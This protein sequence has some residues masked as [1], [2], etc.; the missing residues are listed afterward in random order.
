[1]AA[2]PFVGAALQLYYAR[3]ARLL[4]PG[5]FAE[6]AAGSVCPVC[7]M[8]PAAAVPVAGGTT[9]DVRML[10]CPLC[11]TAWR[12]VGLK[13]AMCSG[14]RGLSHLSL[15]GTVGTTQAA[16]TPH[17]ARP[18]IASAECCDECRTYLKLIDRADDPCADPLADDL[19]SLALDVLVDE[20]GYVRSGRN[21]L[22]HPGS[23]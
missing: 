17:G 11:S 3:L 7:A 16:A 2:V 12:S 1:V 18:V 19:A 15:S 21:L 6:A 5:D 13:C 20:R 10:H 22:L 8:R 14:T 9:P 4:A 23:R